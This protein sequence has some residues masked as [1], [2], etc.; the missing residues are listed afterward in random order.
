MS[1]SRWHPPH[2]L[3]FPLHSLG[4]VGT[5]SQLLFGA[6][7]PRVGHARGGLGSAGQV[8]EVY[9]SIAT[10]GGCRFLETASHRYLR[11]QCAAGA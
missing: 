9:C 4:E 11:V 3:M 1:L 10:A 5:L 6:E 7:N 8:K 2:A